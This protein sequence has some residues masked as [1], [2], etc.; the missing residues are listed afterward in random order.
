MPQC[1][2]ALR[3]R[4]TTLCCR[5]C[6]RC[7][8]LCFAA[9]L[10]EAHTFFFFF[11]LPSLSCRWGYSFGA[12]TA[13]ARLLYS[14]ATPLLKKAAHRFIPTSTLP[15]SALFCQP[16]NCHIPQILP[17]HLAFPLP[18]RSPLHVLLPS[19]ALPLGHPRSSRLTITGSHHH[20]HQ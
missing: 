6:C 18:H 15:T 2:S 17:G 9:S 16:S 8:F 20:H 1:C 4:L 3:N 13:A 10:E 12:A 5:C 7:P 14:A 11:F 19:I